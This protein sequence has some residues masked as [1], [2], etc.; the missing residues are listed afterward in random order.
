MA[1]RRSSCF[2]SLVGSLVSQCGGARACMNMLTAE[3]YAAPVRKPKVFGSLRA[4]KA[5]RYTLSHETTTAM[6]PANRME[7]ELGN[8]HGLVDD[9]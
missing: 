9:T 2:Q 5:A 6:R 3:C 1:G 4:G 8:L 7:V